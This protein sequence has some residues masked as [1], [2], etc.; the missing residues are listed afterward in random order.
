MEGAQ[1]AR[2]ETNLGMI[3]RLSNQHVVSGWN[4]R[5]HLL[6]LLYLVFLCD[7]VPDWV[8]MGIPG[9]KFLGKDKDG[10]EYTSHDLWRKKMIWKPEYKKVWR[11]EKK[12]EWVSTKQ[13]AQRSMAQAKCESTTNSQAII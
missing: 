5:S 4:D 13:T 2:L 11:T 3:A 1:S 9:E 7:Q 6:Y 10:W 12:Q 8:K